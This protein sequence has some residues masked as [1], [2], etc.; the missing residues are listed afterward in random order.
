[1][2]MSTKKKNGR[3][4]S[5]RKNTLISGM[6]ISDFKRPIAK[7]LAASF[8]DIMGFSENLT[9]NDGLIL[10]SEAGSL[11]GDMMS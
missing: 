4:M 11:L 3:K 6:G 9:K 10:K 7:T 1:M 8:L 2:V 5:P